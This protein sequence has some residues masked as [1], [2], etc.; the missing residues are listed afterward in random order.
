MMD[1]LRDY[2]FYAEDMLHPNKTAIQY[3]WEKFQEVWI[4]N[5]TLKTMHDVEAVQKGIQH[6]PF[7]PNS[8]AY[9]K[10]LLGIKE[11][12]LQLQKIYPHITF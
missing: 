12:K 5:E 2:R 6:K 8:E 4:S 11:K 1:E 9:K 10:F 7:N 3:I